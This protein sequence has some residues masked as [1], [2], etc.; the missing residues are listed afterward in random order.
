MKIRNIFILLSLLA[1]ISCEDRLEIEPAQSISVGAALSSEASIERI[2]VG[3]YDEAGQNDSYGGQLQVISELIGNTNQVSWQGT[4]LSPRQIITKSIL[5]TNGFVEDLWRNGYEVINQ[6]NL[7]IDNVGIITSDTDKK[8]RVEGEARF[9]R[10][11][12]YFDLVR[13]FGAPYVAGQT[14]SQAGVP[15]RLTGITDYSADLS[16]ARNTVEEVYTQIINDLTLA[17]TLLPASNSYFADAAAA[18]ALLA[19]VYLQQGNYTGARDAANNVLTSS[20]HSLASTFADAFNRDSDGDEDIFAFQVTSQ[21]GEN[22][23]VLYYAHEALGGRGGDIAI[24]TDYTALFDSPGVDVRAS[25]SYVSDQNGLDLTSKFTNQFGNIPIIRLA[26]MHLIRAEC[27]QRLGTTVGMTPLAEINTLRARSSAPALGSVD[28]DAILN[29][30]Q[31]ELA[32]EGFLIHD[33]KRT[34][35]TVDGLAYDDGKLVLPIPQDEMD[36]NPLM[37]QNSAYQ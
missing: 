16:V 19:R 29:E 25:F 11:L 24:T 10:A 18:E 2:L 20:G 7:V 34:Q 15:L 4:F 33:Y 27:N 30:R 5:V 17:I 36:T 28:L 12:T 14:N 37:E 9:L 8:N 21:T 31:L 1:I 23:L 6:S 26:E 35:R 32:F 13:H 3:A 22:D